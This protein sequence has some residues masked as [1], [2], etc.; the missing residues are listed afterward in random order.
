[1]ISPPDERLTDYSNDKSES[2]LEDIVNN[3]LTRAIN[4]EQ[5]RALELLI[6]LALIPKRRK[7]AYDIITNAIPSLNQ[8]LRTLPVHYLYVKDHFDESMYF[9]LLKECLSYLGPEALVLRG[10]A[11]QWCFIISRMCFVI[12]SKGSRRIPRATLSYRRFVFMDYVW[13]V[14]KTNA[15]RCLIG[16]FL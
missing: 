13:T 15:K 7:Q 1:M 3:M 9:P 5:G 11:V 6:Q 14:K 8:C 16:F 10:D 12:I 2:K 4:S